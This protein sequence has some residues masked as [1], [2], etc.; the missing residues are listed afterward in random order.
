MPGLPRGQLTPGPRQRPIHWIGIDRRVLACNALG[1]QQ[2]AHERGYVIA[3][4]VA[5]ATTVSGGLGT[6]RL[7]H[8]IPTVGIH[9]SDWSGVRL[10]ESTN[11]TNSRVH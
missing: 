8:T 6:T 3:V 9:R 10:G 4:P 2:R 5:M 1:R 7:V 11:S